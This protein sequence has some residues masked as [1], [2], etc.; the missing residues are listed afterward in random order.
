MAM[1]LGILSR[2]GGTL[3][4]LVKPTRRYASTGELNFHA[5]DKDAVI[6][7][8]KACFADGDA[9]E[10]DG[11]T[12]CYADWWFNVRKSN[13]EPLLRLNLE[14]STPELLEMKKALL[15]PMLGTPE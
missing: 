1:M 4:Q 7:A 15:V 12:V 2:S 8:L 11:V 3:S 10:L 6:A 13:T 5:E 14:A 9:D